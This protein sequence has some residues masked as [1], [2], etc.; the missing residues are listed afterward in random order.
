VGP[1]R[2]FFRSQPKTL[3]VGQRELFVECAETQIK[4]K[5]VIEDRCVESTG[6]NHWCTCTYSLRVDCVTLFQTVVIHML[7][8]S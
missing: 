4:Y 6:K 1:A 3:V 8:V 2:A 7:Y 5:L